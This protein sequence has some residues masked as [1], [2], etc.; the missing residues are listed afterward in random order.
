MGYALRTARDEYLHQQKLKMIQLY[1][2]WWNVSAYTI[3]DDY[4]VSTDCDV[5]LSKESI[6]GGKIPITFDTVNG[7]FYCDECELVTLIGAPKSVKGSFDCSRNK[8]KSLYGAPSFVGGSFNCKQ[9]PIV[10]YKNIHHYIKYV[11]SAYGK[12][13]GKPA[14]MLSV[15]NPST[16]GV[17]S[18]TLIPGLLYWLLVDGYHE[19]WIELDTV[20]CEEV[21]RILN[22]HSST[23]DILLC[24]EEM[25]DAGYND[26]WITL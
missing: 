13:Y 15:D 4:S 23:K 26:N 18:N 19:F 9:N 14:I 12:H 16:I 22:Q 10:T 7:N 1:L 24:Q 3:N 17:M 8:I 6:E 20:T 21:S 5:V 2:T 11:G 25:I